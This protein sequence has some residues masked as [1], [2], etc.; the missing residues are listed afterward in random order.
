ME[1]G[2]GEV[3]FDRLQPIRVKGMQEPVPIFAPMGKIS[4]LQFKGLRVRHHTFIRVPA[5]ISEKFF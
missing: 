3:Q 1:G 5:F 4:Q 2:S